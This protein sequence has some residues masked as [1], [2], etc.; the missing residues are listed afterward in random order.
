MQTRSKVKSTL[1]SSVHLCIH[2]WGNWVLDKLDYWKL[3]QTTRDYWKVLEIT[4]ENWRLLDITW[5]SA[6]YW[7]LLEAIYTLEIT[8]GYWRPWEI[9][10]EYWGLL[11]ITGGYWG[12]QEKTG[13]YYS[14]RLVEVT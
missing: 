12:L 4:R 11:E 9:T 13:N 6:D 10:G 14:W 8:D 5:D 7:Q 1:S 2:W 3:L